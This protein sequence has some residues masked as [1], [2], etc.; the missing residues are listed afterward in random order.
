MGLSWST[1]LLE[2]INFLVLVWI[3]NRFLY[4]PVL[5]LINRRRGSIEKDMDDAR[6]LHEEADAL[7][8]QYEN[9][10]SDWE[11][12]QRKARDALDQELDKVRANKLAELDTELEQEKKK[13]EVIEK[14]RLQDA[15]DKIEQTALGQA[16]RFATQLLEQVAGPELETRLVEMAMK[17]I[18]SLPDE[19]ID[20]LRSMWTEAPAE[21][22]VESAY[23]LQSAQQQS[24][25]KT[26]RKITGQTAPVNFETNPGLI[27][28]LQ[29]TV[30]PWILHLNLRDEM[31]SFAD[32][33]HGPR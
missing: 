13:N 10:L 20:S 32:L 15:V 25:E 9:R 30:G 24:L 31:K 29:V 21:M 22:K 19:R 8:Q 28:G 27:A 17:E 7:R 2:I 26:L 33:S 5:N 3:L 4:R 12:E 18:A 1:F 14:R 11:L 23:P 6:K 16:S